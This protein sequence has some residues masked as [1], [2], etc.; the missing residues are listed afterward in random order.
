MYIVCDAPGH[1]AR[2]A[3]IYS[4]H[5]TASDALSAAGKDS[6]LVVRRWSGPGHSITPAN[7]GD[8]CP[9]IR[10]VRW[11]TNEFGQTVEVVT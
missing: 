4:R 11:E 5:E 8:L 2:S 9:I 1:Y 6:S 7:L 3:T 10:A